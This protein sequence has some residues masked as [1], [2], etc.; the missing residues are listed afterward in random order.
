MINTRAT[1][2]GG[3]PYSVAM[4][5]LTVVAVALLPAYAFRL[6]WLTATDG[7][8][9]IV[10][11]VLTFDGQSWVV[12]IA[13]TLVW[14]AA[15]FLGVAVLDG[16][17]RPLRRTLR[18]LPAIGFL[19]AVIWAL[20]AFAFRLLGSIPPSPA[21]LLVLAAVIVGIPGIVEP[22]LLRVTAAVVR[23]IAGP[24]VDLTGQRWAVGVQLVGG[25]GLPL[26]VVDLLANLFHPTS[27][28]GGIAVTAFTAAL[29]TVCAAIQSVVLLT[30]YHRLAPATV[31][32]PRTR[33]PRW[34]AAVGALAIL[35]PAG[36]TAATAAAADLPN[37]TGTPVHAG[38]VMAIAWPAGRHP[39]IVGQNRIL[40]CLD[41]PCTHFTETKLHVIMYEP[42]GNAVIRTDGTVYAFG[43]AE[44]EICDPQRHCDWTGG[45]ERAALINP[46]GGYPW[47]ATMA[48]G[49][50]GNPV[51][52]T[53]A[54]PDQD[55]NAKVTVH[56]CHDQFCKTADASVL[57]SVRMTEKD[58]VTMRLAVGADGQAVVLIHG[59]DGTQQL[60][61][62]L[63][64]SAGGL[65]FA[66]DGAI[67]RPGGGWYS[68]ETDHSGRSA[69]LQAGTP[70]ALTRS[71]LLVCA[72]RECNQIERHFPIAI[73]PPMTSNIPGP[74]PDEI[75]K[76][77][78]GP[79]G[80]LVVIQPEMA[81]TLYMVT[82]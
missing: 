31:L 46:L 14:A 16:G 12:A 75:W 76:I 65:S 48:L 73:G 50:D 70:T 19:V 9:R 13:M 69:L 7:T 36:L 26:F 2:V 66:G 35:V 27:R 49:P 61:E 79:D 10:D 34:I 17:P 20:A 8:A 57:D 40:D 59:T 39:V 45:A 67:E 41:D 29:L 78:P 62:A 28:L 22:V 23:G 4:R 81:D 18:A 5:L 47:A 1:A 71:E 37:V 6:G 60:G 80:R 21:V 58:G 72:D 74:T 30:I 63:P 38:R 64:Q 68:V 25:L 24:P 3:R 11:G 15:V 33:P 56:R 52:A 43:Q 82:V 54:N 42:N 44:L 32:T 53:I 77:A 51:I 55:H